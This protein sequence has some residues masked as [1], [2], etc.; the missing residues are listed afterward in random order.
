MAAV[1][2]NQIVGQLYQ[3][4]FRFALRLSGNSTDAEDFTQQT[5]YLAQQ[6][7]HQLRNPSKIKS[8]LFTTLYRLFLQKRRHENRFPKEELEQA[9]GRLPTVSS[10]HINQIDAKVVWDCMGELEMRYR[11]PLL[12][13]YLEDRSYKEIAETLA[14]PMGTV[15]SRLSRGK[16]LLREKLESLA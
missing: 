9:G 12:M 2:D 3:P 4:L 5:F 7:G 8:W 14:V 13:F 6:K 10:N 16:Q 1:I 15:M 11:E